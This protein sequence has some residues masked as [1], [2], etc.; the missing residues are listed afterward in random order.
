MNISEDYTGTQLPRRFC[1]IFKLPSLSLSRSCPKKASRS[2]SATPVFTRKTV[3][4]SAS[5]VKVYLSV[6]PTAA[7]ESK[8]GAVLVCEDSK[9]VTGERCNGHRLC[10]SDAA[11]RPDPP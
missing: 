6:T 8:C 4:P 5:N 11:V 10:Y 1:N 2:I 7:E 9:K 3:K